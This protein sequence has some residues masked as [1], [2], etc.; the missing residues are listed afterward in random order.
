MRYEEVFS[1]DHLLS[2]AM[3]CCKGVRWKASTQVYEAALPL[4]VAALHDQLISSTWKSKG[5]NTFHIWERGKTRKIQAVH[6]TERTVQKC[7]VHYGLRPLIMPRLIAHSYATLPGK[8]T[9]A[10]LKQHKEHLRWWYARHRRE[11]CIVTMDYHDYFASVSHS[12]L[13]AI[14]ARLPMDERLYRLTCYLIDC[15]DGDY[16]LGLGSEISQISSLLY[17]NS[18][19]HL[20]KDQLGIHCYGRYMDDAYLIADK[21]HAQDALDALTAES[22]RLGLTFNEKATQLRSLTQGWHYLKKRIQLT[23]T[24]RVVMRLER[25]NIKRARQRIKRNAERVTAG[26]MSPESAEQSWQSWLAYARR[27]DAWNTVN[28]MASFNEV[29]RSHARPLFL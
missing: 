5:F 17:I 21:R 26:T 1:Y 4:K 6:I 20:A 13:K 15:F 24:G 11:G 2:A 19:D 25:E 10:A 18:V 27:Y 28:V 7:L 14:Y 9:E 12:K 16:G 22:H 3:A 29:K 8:G 23:D